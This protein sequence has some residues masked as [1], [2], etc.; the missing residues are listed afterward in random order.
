MKRLILLGVVLAIGALA[1][2]LSGVPRNYAGFAAWEK[3]PTANLPTGGP[4][5]GQ[6]KMV[7]ANPIAAKDWK[8]GKPL[9]IGSIVVKTTGPASAPTLIAT[10]EK[11]SN[12]WYYEEY[13]PEGGRYVLKFGGPNGQALCVNCHSGA[14][15]R[16]YLFVR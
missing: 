10:M 7:F 16:D 14:Q 11:R 3:I 8:S 12:G 4:H 2:S 13:L 1:Q 5:P 6:Q 15:A 9:P